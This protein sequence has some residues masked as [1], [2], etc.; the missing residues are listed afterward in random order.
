MESTTLKKDTQSRKYQLTINNPLDIEL[1]IS[2]GNMVKCPFDHEKIKE[3]LSK[4]SS[5]VYWCMA[6]EIGINGETPHTHIYFVAHSPIRF[7]TVKR[8]F[9]TAHIES[10]YGTSSENRAYISKSGKHKEP[11][12]KKT[13]VNGTFEEWGEIPANEKMGKRGEQQYIVD[14]IKSGLS[15]IEIIEIFPNALPYL[16]NIEHTRQL[17]VEEEYRDIFRDS[18][19]VTYLYGKTGTGKTRYIMD[20]YGYSRVFRVTD[21]SHPFDTYDST[22]HKVIVFEE[23]RSSLKIRDML[24]YLDKYP[25]DL[26]ARYRNKVATYE[27]VYITTTIP[28]EKQYLDVQKDSPETWRA[29]LRRINFV[30]HY[31]DIGQIIKYNSIDEYYNRDIEF[32]QIADIDYHNL[33]F[34]S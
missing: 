19:S 9:P 21:Y 31:Q 18:L 10:A 16:R 3:R 27:T 4:I 20:K 6:D 23:F 14:M 2:P 33:P 13:S 30:W 28:L 26:P 5:I 24:I 25:C 1:E 7:S 32:Q 34:N 8:H 22:R 12:D 29:F 11:D 17:L 15:D